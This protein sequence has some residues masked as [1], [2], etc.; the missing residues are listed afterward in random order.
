MLSSFW[1]LLERLWNHLVFW[2]IVDPWERALRVRFGRHITELT[3]GIAL[4]LPIVDTVYKQTVRRRVATIPPQLLSTR[5]GR[6]V[7]VALALGYEITDLRKLY[8][9]LHHAE[10]TL[11]NL[12]S[13]AVAAFVAQETSTPDL[14]R[15]IERAVRDQLDFSRFGLGE[16][17]LQV[18]D[19]AY[20]RPLRVVMDS[21]WGSSG[22]HLNT[23]RPYNP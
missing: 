2:I 7:H 11:R 9:T 6:V 21:K 4:K 14:P 23:A 20:V 18:T 3:P 19:F 8:Q 13:A 22:D 5:D 15:A 16:V 1:Q 12:A 17:S 10:D